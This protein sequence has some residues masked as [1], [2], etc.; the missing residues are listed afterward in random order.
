MD[1]AEVAKKSGLP[2][3]ALRYYEEKGLIT[4][5]GR[6][7]LRRTFAPGVL[8]QLALIALGQAAGFS[9]DDIG[10]MFSPDGQ[11]SIDRQSLSAKADELD[12]TIKR[13]K[14]MRNGLR[15]AAVCPAPSH[16]ECPTFQRLLRSAAAGE[17][18]PRV[19]KPVRV[20]SKA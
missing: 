1:I 10:A 20:R 17:L 3:S 4:S 9:L 7:G 5:A 12:N 14:A 8:D 15:H 6:Q 11:A 16:A 19:R 13:L 18:T 2:A